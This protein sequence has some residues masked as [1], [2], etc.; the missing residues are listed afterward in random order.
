MAGL[1]KPITIGSNSSQ[2]SSNFPA[3]PAFTP[4]VIV[5]QDGIAREESITPAELAEV[6]KVSELYNSKIDA[7]Q[8]PS[9]HL[10]L[11]QSPRKKKLVKYSHLISSG[12]T[13]TAAASVL[14]VAEKKERKGSVKSE[15]KK[16]REPCHYS[17]KKE[18]LPPISQ[19]Q[20]SQKIATEEKKEVKA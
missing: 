6:H 15:E 1:I 20:N 2:G 18:G 9:S 4:Y 10:P 3:P 17:R 16:Q 11:S 14:S 19:A 5:V 8:P 12:K 13:H 7:A